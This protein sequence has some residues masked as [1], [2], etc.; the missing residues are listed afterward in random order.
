MSNYGLMLVMGNGIPKN[1]KDG[2]KYIKMAID[3]DYSYA[4]AL[5][6]FMLQNGENN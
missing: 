1:I 2:V 4:M 3:K 6:A 5:Y